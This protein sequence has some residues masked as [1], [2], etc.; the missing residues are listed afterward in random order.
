M[1]ADRGRMQ[2]Y[3]QA[4]RQV[5]TPDSVVLDIGT[6]TGI[7]AFLACQ[8]GARRVYAIEPSDIIQV[9][10]EIAAANGFAGR[11][12]FIEAL[13]T[14]ISLPE[15]ADIIVSDVR[16]VLPFFEQAIPTLIDARRRLL[17][18]GGVLIPYQDS[19]WAALA[20]APDIFQ[21]MA[22]PW[23]D[24][25]Y[26]LDMQAARR[27]VTN[28]YRKVIIKP[29]QLLEEPRCWATLDY[30]T[31]EST[32]AS[33]ELTWHITCNGLVHGLAVWFDS[34]LAPGVSFSNAPGNPVLIY[35]QFFFPW[36]EPVSLAAGDT[37][38]I[39]LNAR[40]IGT[41]YTW[42]W[43]TRI[44]G[45]ARSL[46]AEF[47]QSDFFGIP[48]STAKLP[49]TAA[50]HVPHLSGDGMIDGFILARMNGT[51]SLGEIAG[52]LVK[53]FPGQFA[54]RRE[55]LTRVGELSE[56]YSQ[57]TEGKVG[58]VDAG[59]ALPKVSGNAGS[60]SAR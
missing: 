7:M 48:L 42:K 17:A 26:G 28:E 13:S 6:G 1:I 56:K 45:A 40:L 47:N 12:E 52:D 60:R 32:A 51:S 50:S 24:N 20:M 19:L 59:R 35:G 58:A 46:K 25:P 27:L 21:E 16:G 14:E 5:I 38:S 31:V 3:R 4:L 54:N 9:A 49:L 33:G 10:R 36:P 57:S 30:A 8:L 53:Q 55:A 44:Q 15:P 23:D 29:Q 41:D 22:G 18:P 37:V 39:S 11:I 43:H 34:C 2:A